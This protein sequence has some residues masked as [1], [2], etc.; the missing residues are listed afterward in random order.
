MVWYRR[1]SSLLS[2][3][4][5]PSSIFCLNLAFMRC[6]RCTED[7]HSW[8]ISESTLSRLRTSSLR[9]VS[10]VEVVSMVS[11]ECL[12]R[13]WLLWCRVSSEIPKDLAEPPTSLDERKRV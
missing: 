2:G 1:Y 8:G 3:A 12:T 11:G 7:D 9:L 5:R 13:S 10:C 4:M 6:Q